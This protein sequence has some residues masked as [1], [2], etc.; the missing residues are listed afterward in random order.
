MQAQYQKSDKI[1]ESYV[2]YII[3]NS[4]LKNSKICDLNG[5]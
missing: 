5:Q 4:P 3:S 2:D 1:V